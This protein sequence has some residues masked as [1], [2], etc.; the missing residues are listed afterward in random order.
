MLP[1]LCASKGPTLFAVAAPAVDCQCV[2]M[3]LTRFRALAAQR[4][5]MA[6]AAIGSAMLTLTLG[7]EGPRRID[8]REL[9]ADDTV[10]AGRLGHPLG[11]VVVV[12]ASL[13]HRDGSDLGP[14][15]SINR[16]YSLRL[17][18]VNGTPLTKPLSFAYRHDRGCDDCGIPPG[19]VTIPP[20]EQALTPEEL[21]RKHVREESPEV[22]HLLF[23]HEEA[24]FSGI[25]AN[26]PPG[27]RIRASGEWNFA[28]FSQLV[29]HHED[30]VT[31]MPT[32]VPRDWP[33]VF[34]TTGQ[35]PV[36]TDQFNAGACSSLHPTDPW[37]TTKPAELA[38]VM[39]RELVAQA[40]RWDLPRH[41]LARALDAWSKACALSRESGVAVPVGAGLFR[42]E[43]ETAWVI[44]WKEFLW[45][46]QTVFGS[47]RCSAQAGHFFS[48]VREA[49][50][51]VLRSVE[52][53][54]D[55]I[56]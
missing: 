38:S 10:V 50:A 25:P 31:R 44:A 29:I 19:A 48:V 1:T 32:R 40:G 23:V 2:R 52:V 15:Y 7:A 21:S 35:A 47:V 55:R 14:S 28:F 4:R 36:T 53:W 37:L 39:T 18:S 5:V 24:E 17:Y 6:C 41:S 11:T 34:S 27:M 46:E 16:E 26:L 49:D 56:E 51:E 20:R 22:R 3:Q 13:H 33:L 8:V 12:E 30:A 9:Q 45:I 42:H 43:E 54:R